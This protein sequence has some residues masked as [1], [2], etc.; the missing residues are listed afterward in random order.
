MKQ[1][2]EP[3]IQRMIPIG[4]IGINIV[5]DTPTSAPPMHIKYPCGDLLSSETIFNPLVALVN[6]KAKAI[7]ARASNIKYN[8][9][10]S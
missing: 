3:I 8:A 1:Q 4:L 7:N 5:A 6:P 10:V 9:T 2:I